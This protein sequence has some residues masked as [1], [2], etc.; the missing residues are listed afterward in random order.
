MMSNAFEIIQ[1]T[2]V[3]RKI[4]LNENSYF[5]VFN[6]FNNRNSWIINKDLKYKLRHSYV[7]KLKFIFHIH[8]LNPNYQTAN[9]TTNQTTT[10]YTTNYTSKLPRNQ[11][12]HLFKLPP[13]PTQNTPV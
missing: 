4:E 1:F 7:R 8:P 5:I 9:Q 13:K 11:P 2:K 10:N 3:V 12:T 6:T